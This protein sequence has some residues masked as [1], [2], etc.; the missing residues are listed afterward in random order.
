MSSGAMNSSSL[1]SSILVDV[2]SRLFDSGRPATLA[3]VGLQFA[4]LVIARTVGD[5]GGLREP[6]FGC[7]VGSATNIEAAWSST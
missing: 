5:Q 4:P 7:V 1:H 6:L 3:A 2:G